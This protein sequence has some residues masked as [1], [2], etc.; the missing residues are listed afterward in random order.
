MSQVLQEMKHQLCSADE[1]AI[2]IIA[3]ASRRSSHFHAFQQNESVLNLFQ[4]EYI[5]VNTTTPTS[6]THRLAVPNGGTLKLSE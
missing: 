5:G 2:D 6:V 1:I 3:D 4:D